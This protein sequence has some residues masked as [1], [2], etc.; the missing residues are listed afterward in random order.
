VNR[1]YLYVTIVYNIS[2]TISLY[3]LVLFYEATKEI[4]R[5]FK[6]VYMFLCIKSIIF[7]SFWQGVI[8]AVMAHFGLLIQQEGDWTVSDVATATQNTLIC[9]EL[10]PCSIAFALTFSY[11]N[12]ITENSGQD[13]L[14]T[15]VINNFVDIANLRD[16]VEDTLVSLKMGPARQVQVGDFLDL[17]REEQLMRVIYQGFLEKRGEDLGKVWVRRYCLV[18]NNPFGLVYFKKHPFIQTAKERSVPLKARGFIDLNDARDV[19]PRDDD[20]KRFEIASPTRTWHFR[21]KNKEERDFWVDAIFI[22]QSR[23]WKDTAFPPPPQFESITSESERESDSDLLH[24]FRWKNQLQTVELE[25][26]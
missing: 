13:S 9:F 14:A 1:G 22:A 26:V 4:L 18:I 8:I 10:V 19:H 21:C 6:P 23:I 17:T 12:Y 16:T 2:I 7:F 24:G 20:N 11:K 3:F 25:D 15:Y 5:R